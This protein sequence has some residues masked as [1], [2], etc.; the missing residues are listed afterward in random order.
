MTG[1]ILTDDQNSKAVFPVAGLGTR[2]QPTTEPM[3][4]KLLSII[5]NPVILTQAKTGS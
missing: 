3:P 5:D 4:E 1:L 2:F